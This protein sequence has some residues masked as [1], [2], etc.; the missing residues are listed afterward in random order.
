MLLKSFNEITPDYQHIYLSPHFD[1]V[2]YSCGG[3]IGIQANAGQSPLVITVFAGVPSAELKLSPF[4]SEIHKI[5]GFGCDVEELITTRRRED[6]SALDCLHADY[7]WLDYLDAIYRGNPAYYTHS[8]S[9]CG[10][11]NPADMWI[12]KQLAQ[13][14]LMLHER[15]PDVTWYAPLGVGYHVDHQL[16][17]SAMNH[18]IRCGVNV[19]LYEDFPYVGQKHILRRNVL[20]RRLRELG[21]NLKPVMV[22]ISESMHL[23]LQAAEAYASQVEL[24]FCSRELMHK[25]MKDYTRSIHPDRRG[26]TERYWTVC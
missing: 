3:T 23:R 4:A 10:K 22:E 17:S 18:L 16:V 14:L 8:R 12:E 2:V 21:G 13:D 7:L 24:N 1:D 9:V 6:A 26:Y 11:I 19:K 20:Q 15:L 25:A 5:M